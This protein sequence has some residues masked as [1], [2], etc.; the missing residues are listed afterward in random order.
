MV[1]GSRRA[2]PARRSATWTRGSSRESTITSPASGDTPADNAPAAAADG[3]A[4]GPSALPGTTPAGQI[5]TG[6]S[7]LV[8]GDLHNGA[9]H[10]IHRRQPTLKRRSHT[11]S[12]TMPTTVTCAPSSNN[13]IPPGTGDVRRCR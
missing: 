12:P 1:L 10:R 4:R 11:G 8:T 3:R 5:D 2:T 6:E 9:G 13:P 7:G